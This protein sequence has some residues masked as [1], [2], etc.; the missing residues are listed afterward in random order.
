MADDGQVRIGIYV[1]N[2]GVKSSMD[3]ATQTVKQGTKE[4]GEAAEE[5]GKK[6]EESVSKGFDA[7]KLQQQFKSVASQVRTFAKT[8]AASAT[9]FGVWVKQSAASIDRIDKMSQKLGISRKAFQELDYAASRTGLSV[10]Q[11]SGAM[12]AL[13]NASQS[14]G[15]A[16]KRLGVSIK[17]A[18]G[19]MKSQEDLFFDVVNKLADMPAG[20][21]RTTI[22]FELLGRNFQQ[23][24]PLINM[25]S[26]GIQELRDKFHDLGL[27]VSDKTIDDFVDFNDTLTDFSKTLKNSFNNALKGLVPQLKVAVQNVTKM[28]EPGG[29]LA[30]LIEKLANILYKFVTN[31]L[32]PFIDALNWIIDNATLVAAG[33]TAIAVAIKALMGNWVGAAISGIIGLFGTVAVASADAAEKVDDVNKS[34]NE[35]DKTL[36]ANQQTT[37]K[38]KGN[39]EQMK[40]MVRLTSEEL[41]LLKKKLLL[42]NLD[43]SIRG[44][45][46]FAKQQKELQARIKD[47]EAVIRAYT[48][49][50][51]EYNRAQ[52]EIEAMESQIDYF[53]DWTTAVSK[54]EQQLR[55][56]IA[57]K[58]KDSKTF[59][60]DL[61]DEEGLREYNRLTGVVDQAKTNLAS[62]EDA[63]E[64]A[65]KEI[66]KTDAFKVWTDALS[67]ARE[68]LEKFVAQQATEM[69]GVFDIKLLSEDGKKQ[70]DELKTR[71]DN[72][73]KALSTLKSALAE[74][75]VEETKNINE[76]KIED[77]A[78]KSWTDAVSNAEKALKTFIAS[79]SNADTGFSIDTLSQED[80]A[81]YNRL[82]D[83][84]V[85]AQKALDSMN[86]ALRDTK[87]NVNE[88]SEELKNTDA[89]AKW[90]AAVDEAENALKKFIATKAESSGG[91]FDVSVLSDSDKAEFD[92]LKQ[93]L[94]DAK[95]NLDSLQDVFVDKKEE[96]KTDLADVA[97]TIA[98]A[99]GQV[100]LAMGNGIEAVIQSLVNGS[101]GLREA[102]EGIADTFAG[103]LSAMGDAI[104]QTGIAKIVEDAIKNS[105][106]S[107]YTAIAMG[108]AIKAAAGSIKGLFD[109]WR[110]ADGYERGGIIGGNSYTGDR[111]LARVN[112]GEMILNRQ[113]QRQ[114]FA[115]ANGAV[116]SGTGSN[117]QIINNAGD[118]V[119]A[120]QS[121]DG[122]SIKIMVEKFTSNML[123][124]VKGSKLMGQ[125]YG[126]R[127]LG[128][129]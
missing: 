60:L 9:S 103:I 84:A 23:L 95:S 40:E 24:A 99:W 34:I 44:T 123:R 112:S 11:F 74:T 107:G 59:S 80:L 100:G 118:Q 128:R 101:Q 36:K 77:D 33:I 71:F 53:E 108:T 63:F 18:T 89:F 19:E 127:Q 1:D 88:V 35:L 117:I 58:A 87:T 78:F 30:E 7:A 49:A 102:V 17:T 20:I 47:N 115:L 37:V 14:G 111:L 90:T 6:I 104:I 38:V 94:D 69:G 39:I 46:E 81:E 50:I 82:K 28:L 72:T 91:R 32:P 122:R 3:Q 13:V 119:T 25:G 45:E 10:T 106:M 16:L 129:H 21:E 8:I 116:G 70:Y 26:A 92:R 4:M 75:T 124:G 52:A 22:G 114:L 83:E 68:E 31:V 5:A 57:E 65:N 51:E 79:K 42:L 55:K 97:D 105:T 98:S 113:Q 76:T 73:S 93:V 96:I 109:K 125:T 85:N 48:N 86:A 67:D 61:L 126:I 56:F 110:N 2:E 12:R 121:F 29:K 15:D 43:K 41:E 62:L 66:A 27:E 54:A 120:E 64:H